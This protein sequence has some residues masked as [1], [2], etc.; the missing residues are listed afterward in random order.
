MSYR[1]HAYD[2]I[3]S[4][5]FRRSVPGIGNKDQIYFLRQCVCIF[6]LYLGVCVLL[7][8]CLPAFLPDRRQYELF[9]VN[10]LESVTV[11]NLM[12]TWFCIW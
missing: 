9:L 3:N 6:N 7:S 1:I 8:V 4:R 2:S 10:R 5:S 11:V 12:F